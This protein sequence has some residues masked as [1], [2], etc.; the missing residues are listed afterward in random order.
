MKKHIQTFIDGVELLELYNITELYGWDN[1]AIYTSIESAV[2]IRHGEQLLRLG[3]RLN[4][5]DEWE[6][7]H[8]N[9]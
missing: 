9:D 5:N 3:W 2:S 6:W 4:S 7:V 1:G 8:S